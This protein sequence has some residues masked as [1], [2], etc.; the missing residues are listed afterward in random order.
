MLYYAGEIQYEGVWIECN[1]RQYI[2]FRDPYKSDWSKIPVANN[3]LASELHIAN[4]RGTLLFLY[5]KFRRRIHT[6]TSSSN[7]QT[8]LIHVYVQDG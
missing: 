3:G 7:R 6:Y 4:L 5:N 2:D 8:F 1:A